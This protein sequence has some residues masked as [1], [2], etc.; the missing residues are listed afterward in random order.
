MSSTDDD[1]PGPPPDSNQPPAEDTLLGHGTDDVLDEG[2]SPPDRSPQR[3]WGETAYEEAVGEP[4]DE[5]FAE[6][7]PQEEP[8]PGPARQADR[9]G[10]LQDLGESDLAEDVGVAGGGAGAEEAAMRLH[11]DEGAP[12]EGTEAAAEAVG[13]DDPDRDAPGA[14][15]QD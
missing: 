4:M 3:Y 10:R 1:V 8:Y 11:D 15:T 5:E 9:A 6:E 13:N 14:D 7:V 2:Y 12:P